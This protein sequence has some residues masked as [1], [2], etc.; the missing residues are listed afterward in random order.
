M[1]SASI[2]ICVIAAWGGSLLGALSREKESESPFRLFCWASPAPNSWK[3]ATP[4]T[5]E[6]AIRSK[7]FHHTTD[8]HG[9][10]IRW[11]LAQWTE[12]H[13]P[14]HQ[15]DSV[16]GRDPFVFRVTSHLLVFREFWT[17]END[18]DGRPRKK[19]WIRRTVAHITAGGPNEEDPAIHV[20]AKDIGKTRPGKRVN[21]VTASARSNRG[22]D[23]SI[24]WK[25][26][27]I[28]SVAVDWTWNAP[29]NELE[30]DYRVVKNGRIVGSGDNSL[31]WGFALRK[32]A[33][34]ISSVRESPRTRPDFILPPNDE[35]LA[36]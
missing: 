12:V 3:V 13:N 30:T 34:G 28:A 24:R 14:P 17:Y 22:S 10:G 23:L 33:D 31:H 29:N 7:Q 35:P 26:T 9:E 21:Q 11:G 4:E 16:A 8:E 5:F 1:R 19:E 32:T 25:G 15:R 36:K 27:T 20:W 18:P 2:C 6:N